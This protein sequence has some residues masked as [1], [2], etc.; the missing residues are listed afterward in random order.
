MNSMSHE[1]PALPEELSRDEEMA[2]LL[3]EVAES[4]NTIASYHKGNTALLEA[5]MNCVEFRPNAIPEAIMLLNLAGL[6]SDELLAN[7]AALGQ[8]KAHPLTWEQAVCKLVKQPAHQAQMLGKGR[9]V[10]LDVEPSA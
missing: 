2:M 3:H 9:A 7:R 4:M 8:R 6:M 1:D 10:F 5:L